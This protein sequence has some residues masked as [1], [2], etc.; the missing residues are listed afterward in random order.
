M[1]VVKVGSPLSLPSLLSS[2]SFVHTLF[3]LFTTICL[4]QH[5]R[6]SLRPLRKM[7]WLLIKHQNKR[8]KEKVKLLK[9]YIRQ[10]VSRCA[11]TS[12]NSACVVVHVHNNYIMI[13]RF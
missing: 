7:W 9:N 10:N 5:I 1:K 6:E 12:N 13:M 3:Y 2:L 11:C 8:L 4:R